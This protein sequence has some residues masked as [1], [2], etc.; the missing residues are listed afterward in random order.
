MLVVALIGVVGL[1]IALFAFLGGDDEEDGTPV[2]EGPAE[3]VEEDDEDD[4]TDELPD[5]EDDN[6]DEDDEDEGGFGDDEDEDQDDGDEDIDTNEPLTQQQI[7]ELL[8]EENE[9][10]SDVTSHQINTGT[11]WFLNWVEGWPDQQT[12]DD[13]REGAEQLGD[14]DAEQFVDCSDTTVPLGD[15]NTSES[16]AADVDAFYEGDSYINIGIVS[17]NEAP[18][19]DAIW[20]DAAE[21]CD[22]SVDELD[23]EI[24]FIEIDGV[25]GVAEREPGADVWEYVSLSMDMG[26]NLV[27]VTAVDVTDEQLEDVI[28]EQMDKIEAAS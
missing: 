14:P 20:D 3:P 4:D 11:Q 15:M 12:V 25:R 17:L 2:E 7:E 6:G 23:V 21:Y 19:T 18:E 1:I 5:D 26:E 10:P 8:L 13:A 9:M 27:W 16:A 22:V 28:G 24:G